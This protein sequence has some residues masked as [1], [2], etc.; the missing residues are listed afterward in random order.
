MVKSRLLLTLLLAALGAQAQVPEG[1][2]DLARAR[3]AIYQESGS[4]ALRILKGWYY[5]S[6]IGLWKRYPELPR[7]FGWLQ[8]MTERHRSG[9]MEEYGPFS[10][11]HFDGSIMRRLALHMNLAS[12]GVRAIPYTEKLRVGSVAKSG[13]LF[14]HAESDVPWTGRLCFDWPRSE[15]KAANID[16]ARINEMQEWYTVRAQHRYTVVVDTQAPLTVSGKQLIDGLPTELK[17]GRSRRIHIS[18]AE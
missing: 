18:P 2:W 3:G 12:Q 8:F 16:W 9:W 15:H 6:M 11:D 10:G 7:V 14:V 17:P 13:Q 4:N 1:Y 5:E